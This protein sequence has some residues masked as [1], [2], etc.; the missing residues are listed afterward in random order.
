MLLWAAVPS[1]KADEIVGGIVIAQYSNDETLNKLI[2]CH[3]LWQASERYQSP[4][5]GDTK[6]M[7]E[8]T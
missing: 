7:V 4:S 2:D 6:G 8:Q 3:G 1:G 5:T